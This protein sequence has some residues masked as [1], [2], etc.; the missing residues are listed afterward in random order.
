MRQV[1]T[2]QEP[3]VNVNLAAAQGGNG[4]TQDTTLGF[5][6]LWSLIEIMGFIGSYRAYRF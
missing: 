4:G 2:G 6:V 1:S 3:F 5:R